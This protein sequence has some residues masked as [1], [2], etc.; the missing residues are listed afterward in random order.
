MVVFHAKFKK[1]KYGSRFLFAQYLFIMKFIFYLIYK[2]N[3]CDCQRDLQ[4][5][6]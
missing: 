2:Q 1:E 6:R 3:L 4:I 5:L